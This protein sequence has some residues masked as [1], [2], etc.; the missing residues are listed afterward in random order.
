MNMDKITDGQLTIVVAGPVGFGNNIYV[1][2][3]RETGEAAFIDAPGDAAA[4]PAGG[5][6]RLRWLRFR[7]ASLASPP[8]DLSFDLPTPFTKAPERYRSMREGGTVRD[9]RLLFLLAGQSE[10]VEH[11][12]LLDLEAGTPAAAKVVE[13]PLIGQ[14]PVVGAEPWAIERPEALYALM[15]SR[16]KPYGLGVE[17]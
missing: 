15:A 10:R 14:K 5:R 7:L 1:V 16:D 9:G 8:E 12:V 6:L 11:L 17:V 13:P 4:S 2:I 3:D